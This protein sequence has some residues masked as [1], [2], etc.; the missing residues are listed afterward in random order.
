MIRAITRTTLL[1]TAVALTSGSLTGT[2]AAQNFGESVRNLFLYGRTTEPP[3]KPDAPTE[4]LACPSVGVLDGGAALRQL[5]QGG[6]VRRQI[7]LGQL[8]RECFEQPDGSIRVKVGVELRA[9]IG[10]GGSSGSSDVPVRFVIKSGDRVIAARSRRVAVAIPPNDTQ[11]SAIVVEE[12]LVVPPGTEGFDIE[13]GLGGP[14]D[15]RPR[16]RR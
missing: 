3:P 5:G 11:G 6:S 1:A 15:E 14:T 8:A 9:L 4:D 2:S 10:A 7:S 12:G 16:R 13:V